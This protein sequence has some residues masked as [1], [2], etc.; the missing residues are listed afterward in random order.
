MDEAGTEKLRAQYKKL[1]AD[2]KLAVTGAYFC[3]RAA[4]GGNPVFTWEGPD[5]IRGAAA[6]P[7]Q[8]FLAAPHLAPEL[9][10]RLAKPA[11]QPN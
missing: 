9:A 8:T 2:Y 6:P 3:D 11:Q 10:D 7:L 5:G 4:V 1:W